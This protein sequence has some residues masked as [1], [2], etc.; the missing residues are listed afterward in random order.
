MTSSG[1][2]RNA[3]L[4]KH[5]EAP[6]TSPT[7]AAR[8]WLSCALHIDT[9]PL[10]L[11]VP[12]PGTAKSIR[13]IPRTAQ[14]LAHDAKYSLRVIGSGTLRTASQPDACHKR[15]PICDRM[16]DQTPRSPHSTSTHTG[17][18]NTAWQD[19]P[20]KHPNGGQAASNLNRCRA[21]VAVILHAQPRILPNASGPQAVFA[22]K[23]GMCKDFLNATDKLSQTKPDL[24]I[25]Q[26]LHLP[27]YQP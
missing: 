25:A 16:H 4:S 27:M 15:A 5:R 12:S 20:E 13:P 21:H 2:S 18:T 23:C 1:G 6:W 22:H 8:A 19:Q 26:S 10:R 7:T 17:L 3:D 24:D 11:R 14:G 9:Y